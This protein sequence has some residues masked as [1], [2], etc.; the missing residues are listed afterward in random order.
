MPYQIKQIPSGDLGTDATVQEMEK[1]IREG[2]KEPLVRELALGLIR[3][4]APRDY[5]GE[6]S[7]IFQWVQQSIRYTKDPVALE[8]LQSARRILGDRAGDCDDFT[9]LTSALLQAIGHQTRIKTIAVRPGEYHHVYPEVSFQGTWL[10]LDASQSLAIPGWQPPGIQRQKVYE[11]L[12]GTMESYVKSNIDP[13][14]VLWKDLQTHIANR[15]VNVKDL[16]KGKELISQQNIPGEYA[17]TA[18]QMID[19]VIRWIEE[20]PNYQ[21]VQ[22]LAGMSGL[23]DFWDSVQNFIKNVAEISGSIYQT[24]TTGQPSVVTYP[25]NYNTTQAY[26]VTKSWFAQLF[27]P[28]TLYYVLGGL[29]LLLFGPKLLK[30]M[31][32]R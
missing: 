6:I 19:Q 2:V 10:P 30:S 13:Y 16:Q 23:G 11:N 32:G 22:S 14:A 8:L 5:M 17:T 31:K 1:L 18:G 7:R 4:I 15:S 24:T 29:A 3:G 27:Q 25:T 12:G 20:N 9:I 21:K 26:V 28:P